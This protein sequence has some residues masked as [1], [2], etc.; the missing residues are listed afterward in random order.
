MEEH[1]WKPLE[2]GVCNYRGGLDESLTTPGF[3]GGLGEEA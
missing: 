1:D 3:K 2:E